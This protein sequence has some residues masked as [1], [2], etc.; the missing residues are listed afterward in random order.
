VFLLL[1]L[2]TFLRYSG[3][4]SGECIVRM[5]LMRDLQLGPEPHIYPPCP[6]GGVPRHPCG[7]TKFL[8]SVGD[9]Q[10]AGAAMRYVRRPSF[11][12]AA[13]MS[14]RCRENVCP[15]SQA[16]RIWYFVFDLPYYDGRDLTRLPL[17]ERREI[18]NSVLKFRSPKV[19]IAQYFEASAE[20]M[21]SSA[22]EQ[23][24]RAS[25]RSRRTADTKQGSAAAHGR[26]S[27]STQDWNL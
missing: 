19:R 18:L 23:G 4:P 14:A 17:V 3:V 11:V 1:R 16:S 5:S 21:L 24:L 13:A 22:R 6:F 12:T 7:E 27:G 25:L 26:N 9:E 20:T 8:E 2:S 10:G 15:G